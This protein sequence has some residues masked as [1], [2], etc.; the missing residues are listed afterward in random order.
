VNEVHIL[1]ANHVRGTTRGA[2]HG[3]PAGR[4]DRRRS[5]DR[6]ASMERLWEHV[7][8]PLTLQAFDEIDRRKV[9]QGE[10]VS[11]G[12]LEGVIGV[13]EMSRWLNAPIQ[14]DYVQSKHAA[15]QRE[16]TLRVARGKSLGRRAQCASMGTG[17]TS[18]PSSERELEGFPLVGH[19]GM[20]AQMT[21]S[22]TGV[23][24]RT[25]GVTAPLRVRLERRLQ[26]IR[27]P[28]AL[29]CLEPLSPPSPHAHL[30]ASA[31]HRLAEGSSLRGHGSPR[32]PLPLSWRP[33]LGSWHEATYQ[34]R[35]GGVSPRRRQCVQYAGAVMDELDSLPVF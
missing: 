18:G 3:S 32:S 33:P 11:G 34:A 35:P 22:T 19:G 16:A 9:M 6:I 8:H 15:L 1:F 17:M 13:V 26:A 2:T 7:L 10:R 30:L 31:T 24:T 23:S 14:R 29:V 12:V 27:S 25:L 21:S 20:T 4:R 5:V 28:R